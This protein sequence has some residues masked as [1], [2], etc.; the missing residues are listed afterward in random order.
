HLG[1]GMADAVTR[2]H[3]ER[4][5]QG[6]EQRGPSVERDRTVRERR[7]H[8]RRKP[9]IL[10]ESIEGRFRLRRHTSRLKSSSSRHDSLLNYC[11]L[12]TYAKCST[13]ATGRRGFCGKF[14]W[15][16]G[17][18]DSSITGTSPSVR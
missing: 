14:P 9:D 12:N 16:S 2:L 5:A 1:D 4:L 17:P 15:R 8:V 11:F 18:T 13:S 10:G 3:V 7:H 6:A